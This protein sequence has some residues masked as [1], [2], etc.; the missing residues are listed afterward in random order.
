MSPETL[1]KRLALAGALFV[2]VTTLLGGS[3]TPALLP[4]LLWGC[5]PWGGLY[6]LAERLP[7]R[8]PLL[9]AGLAG[10][11]G[12]AAARAVVFLWPTGST[13]AILLLFS[14]AYILFLLMPA[15]AALGWLVESAWEKAGA[16]LR[17]VLLLAC[18][19]A[20]LFEFLAIA[21]PQLL[22]MNQAKTRAALARFGDP[23]VI[24][25][26]GFTDV[27]VS[28]GPAWAAVEELDGLP[29]SELVLVDRGGADILS[30]DDYKKKDRAAFTSEPGALWNWYSRL[31]ALED[32]YAVAQTG[33]G[34]Q[35]TELRTLSGQLLWNYKPDANLEPAQLVPA[36]LDRKGGV[37]FYAVSARKLCRLDASMKEEWC[38]P[39]LNASLPAMDP[40]QVKLD[41]VLILHEYRRMLRVLDPQGQE[42]YSWVPP[43]DFLPLAILRTYPAR[44]LVTGGKTLGL[45]NLDGTPYTRGYRFEQPGE[46]VIS[47]AAFQPVAH[48]PYL[49]AV[50]TGAR[51]VERFRLRVID[52]AG[53]TRYHE[54]FEK[55]VGLIVAERRD[56]GESLLLKEASRLRALR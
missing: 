10:L 32:G 20:L 40:R 8:G 41:G 42:L 4:F 53:Q 9:G 19:A 24:D 52:E 47:A 56:G 3:F 27:V 6:L 36:D 26:G 11:A 37:E 34:F 54:V 13:S 48:K 18:G 43:K 49:L 45:F 29:G 12:E 17:G 15:G 55:P 35:K 28:T 25:A 39:A 7:R 22:P 31:V 1:G 21:R 51:G 44:V 5:A 50:L 33:G 23:R 2:A 14:P 30:A 46:Q 16:A 38:V